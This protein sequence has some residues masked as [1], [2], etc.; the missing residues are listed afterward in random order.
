M[1]VV[2]SEA[3]RIS[4]FVKV[5]YS[6]TFDTADALDWGKILNKELPEAVSVVKYEAELLTVAAEEV[7]NKSEDE[8]PDAVAV[9][10]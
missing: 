8:T 3:V 7:A 5:W 1:E 4:A 6:S 10:K 2:L 9:A